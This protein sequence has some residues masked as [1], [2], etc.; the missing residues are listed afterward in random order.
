VTAP[1]GP[2][3]FAEGLA[4]RRSVLGDAYVDRALD[5]S[6]EFGAPWQDFVSRVA[7][8]EAWG[9]PSLSWKIRS[10]L[11][12]ALCAALNREDEFRLHL[13]GALLNG[14]TREEL[15]ALIRHVAVYA[16]APAGNNANRWAVAELSR[17]DAES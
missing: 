9:D 11:T 3:T 15:Q 2:P 13:H 16:G 12:L 6:G 10:L 4:N 17:G 1:A 7:W 8:G 14:A 5:S